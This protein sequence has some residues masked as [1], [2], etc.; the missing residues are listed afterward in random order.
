MF[1]CTSIRTPVLTIAQIITKVCTAKLSSVQSTAIILSYMFTTAV[2]SSFFRLR[3]ACCC[4]PS[5]PRAIM[6]W[7][8]DIQFAITWKASHMKE[9]DGTRT[10]LLCRR[11]CSLTYDM[12]SA[13]WKYDAEERQFSALRLKRNNDLNF[14]IF[15]CFWIESIEVCG[16]Y[17]F[18]YGDQD[19]DEPAV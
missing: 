19:P 5:S 12:S 2:L 7:Q 16:T 14:I 18:R 9:G 3:T 6:E 8:V 11:A 10:A 1:T 4:S 15:C 17:L 13:L